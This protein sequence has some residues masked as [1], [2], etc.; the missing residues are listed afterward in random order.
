LSGDKISGK[1]ERNNRYSAV[2]VITISFIAKLFF[3]P[4][5]GPERKRIPDTTPAGF[6]GGTLQRW[7]GEKHAG[8]K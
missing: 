7:F 2:K 4:E 6:S 5:G 1:P 3:R 8:T